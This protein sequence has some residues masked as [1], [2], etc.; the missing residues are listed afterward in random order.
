MFQDNLFVPYSTVR[1]SKIENV[2]Q[3]T[4]TDTV[5]FFGTFHLIFKIRMVF[6]KLA[7]F[8]FS[9]R[10]APNLDA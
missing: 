8:L 7:P 1:Q 5:F 9:D 2:A 4:L 6:R 3:L 10:E